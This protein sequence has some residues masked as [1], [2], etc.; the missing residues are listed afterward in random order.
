MNKTEFIRELSKKSKLTQKD[1]SNCLN[2]ITQLVSQTL[3]KG[4]NVSLLG[5]GKFEVKHRKARRSF[6]PQTRK[7]IMLPASRIPKFKPGKAL[8]TA[9]S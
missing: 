6:N 1:C 5:F 9:I 7:Q 3:K 2:A 8:K 4:G